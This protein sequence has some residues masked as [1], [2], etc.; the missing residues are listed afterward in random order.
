MP[1]LEL[2]SGAACSPLNSEG[3]NEARSNLP[4][5]SLAKPLALCTESNPPELT[6]KLSTSASTS[7]L[8]CP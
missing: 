1:Q 8:T 5:R 6:H 2:M 7:A 3:Q 4:F